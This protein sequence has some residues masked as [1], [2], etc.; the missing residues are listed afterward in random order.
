MYCSIIY[1][2]NMQEIHWGVIG[3]GN[4]CERK[5]GPA[6][7]KTPHSQLT[8]VMR[9]NEAKAED[10]A[11][12]HGVSRYYTDAMQLINDPQ[13]NAI[14][15]ATPP[16][17]HKKYAIAAMRAG[18]PVYVE[19]PMALNYA[20]CAEM[21][22]VS[23][24]TGQ[25]LFVALYRRALPYFL[26]VKELIDNGAIGCPLTANVQYFRAP[27]ESDLD[28][29]K[30]TWHL[31]K[32]IAGGGYFYDLAP[33]TLDILDFLLGEIEQVYGISYNLGGYYDVEDC[34]SAI[35][36]FKSGVQ[37]VGQ[38][39]FV[40]AP[41]AV[42]DTVEI[43]GS[44]GTL[45]FNTFAFNPIVLSAG[46]QTQQLFAPEQPQHIQQPLI[47]TIVD[48]LRG[49]GCCPSTGANGAQTAWV[50]DKIM[51]KIK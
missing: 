32:D 20:E 17:T 40:A 30:H 34:V 47:Q 28:K 43:T 12:R 26:K 37:G 25:K 19:K 23:Q 42:R 41:Q 29:S 13:V 50:M 31:D 22:H 11:E 10:Y 21:I 38:W 3:C 6:F 24:Q 44:K 46:G 15:V 27:S 33:H 1:L 39:N 36:R 2:K 14:Y 49:E 5:S 48:E 51:S 35:W 8:A 45:C 16:D 18:K 7:Y 9:R 4:V